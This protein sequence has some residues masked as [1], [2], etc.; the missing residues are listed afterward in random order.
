MRTAQSERGRK[1]PPRGKPVKRAPY[2]VLAA[3]KNRQVWLAARRTMVTA[4]DV[5]VILGVVRSKYYGATPFQLWMEKLGMLPEAE[6]EEAAEMGNSMEQFNASLFKQK[7][8][9]RVQREQ[10]LLR[11]TRY[12]W[13]GATLDYTQQGDGHRTRGVLELKSTAKKY[14]WPDSPDDIT[15]PGVQCVSEPHLKW[16]AQLQTQ[17]LVTSLGY[18]SISAVLGQPVFHHRWRDFNAHSQ[19]QALI[20][21]RTREFWRYV[22]TKTPPPVD[23]FDNAAAREWVKQQPEGE[24]VELSAG[25]LE[26]DAELVR[27]KREF[28]DARKRVEY[29]EAQLLLAI[30]G[31]A[32]ATL[33]NGAIY[34]IKKSHVDSY[35]VKGQLRVQL[36]RKE[37]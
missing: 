10:Q 21:E 14:N 30:G 24:Q 4:S 15:Q 29:H 36:K 17:L 6:T 8:G 22:E 2:T 20:L 11:S 25:M 19:F 31:A 13:L 23:A 1:V 32:S 27:A 5:A 33:P 12:P 3:A 7:T 34:E 26:H 37:A 9:R 35:V 18:G 16:Q 28:N